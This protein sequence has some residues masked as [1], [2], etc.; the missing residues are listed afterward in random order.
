MLYNISIYNVIDIIYNYDDLNYGY[1][2]H[3]FIWILVNMSN[4]KNI[5][6]EINFYLYNYTYCKQII[7][8][9]YM[10]Y[11]KNIRLLF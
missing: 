8:I 7:Y 4:V 1:N 2:G 3:E 11:S 5:D 10:N 6:N 9:I